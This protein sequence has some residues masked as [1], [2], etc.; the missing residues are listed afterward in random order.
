MGLFAFGLLSVV[1]LSAS[2]SD[3]DKSCYEPVLVDATNELIDTVSQLKI[4]GDLAYVIDNYQED[5]VILDLSQA[6]FPVISR[7]NGFSNINDIVINDKTAYLT[8]G[9]DFWLSDSSIEIWDIE[10]PVDPWFIRGHETSE[11]WTKLLIEGERMYKSNDLVMNV[12]RQRA[13]KVEQVFPQSVYDYP[14][15][16]I[17]EN[18]A[19]TFGMEVVDL[20]D[21][22]NPVLISDGDFR[23]GQMIFDGRYFHVRGTASFSTFSN[24]IRL[25]EMISPTEVVFIQEYDILATDFVVRGSML[26]ITSEDGL[27]VVDWSNPTRPY[28]VAF[29]Q[30]LIVLDQPTQIERLGNLFLVTD[31]HGSMASYRIDSN[32]VGTHAT[33]GQ[34]NEL[35]LAGDLALVAMNDIGMQ[36]FDVSEPQS[37]KLLSTFETGN[38]AVGIDAKDGVAYIATHQAGLDIVDISDPLNPTLITNFDT[39]RSVQDVQVVGDLA[40]VVDRVHGLFI[41]D[42]ADPSSPILL[43]ITDTPARAS[44][45]TIVD[46]GSRRYAVMPHEQFDLQVLDVTNSSAPMI[47]GS[48]TP[49]DGNTGITRATVHGGLMYTGE[50]TSGY[51]VWDFS[52]PANP[53]ELRRFETDLPGN[54]G[55]GHH[56]AIDGSQLILANGSGGL[57]VYLNADPLRPA[58]WTNFN[59]VNGVGSGLFASYRHVELRDGLA[60]TAARDGGLRI[61]D[62]KGCDAPCFV[63]YNYDGVLD[64]LDITIFLSGFSEDQPLADLD[65]NGIFDFFDVLALINAFRNGC[66]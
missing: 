53:I 31:R 55:F 26:Y 62:Y 30:D 38:D 43:S 2:A 60:F 44:D 25:Y 7:T 12:A 10:D 35:K 45:I 3:H 59:N 64:Y 17:Q 42:I 8:K 65:A 20:G 29:H 49:L 33:G 6:G 52:D 41:L 18:I 40:Y 47:V 32:P 37:P 13:L 5:L 48:I 23:A 28:R 63:D 34:A 14:I 58:L 19:I 22:A 46:Q 56:I 61:F 57:S 16:M 21:P 1:G 39:G 9:E 27:E 4:V 66:P 24:E 50:I 54:D 51:R 11:N 36:I 15:A